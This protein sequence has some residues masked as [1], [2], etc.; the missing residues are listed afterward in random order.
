VTKFEK[1]RAVNFLEYIFGGCQIN[2][3]IAIDF[4]KSNGDP[5]DPDSLHNRMYVNN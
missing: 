3:T 4:T 1:I 2:L 5:S